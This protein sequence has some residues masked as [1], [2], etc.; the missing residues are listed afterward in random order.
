MS[1]RSKKESIDMYVTY[2]FIEKMTSPFREWEAFKLGLIDQTGTLLRA[3]E[4]KQEKEAWGYFDRLARN[5]KIK[6]AHTPGGTQYTANFYSACK[7]LIGGED[8][9]IT[10][11]KLKGISGQA[12]SYLANIQEDGVPVNAVGDASSMAGLDTNPPIKST[13]KLVR[14]VKKILKKRI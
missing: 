14:R 6:L 5:V 4:T 8:P 13:G 10:Y 3:P 7:N 2:A 11:T 12:K 9:H 1:G